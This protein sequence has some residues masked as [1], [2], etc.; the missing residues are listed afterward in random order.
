MELNKTELSSFIFSEN[1]RTSTPVQKVMTDFTRH[2]ETIVTKNTTN[3][4]TRK[5]KLMEASNEPT[6][7]QPHLCNNAVT[8][9]VKDFV[10][11]EP[12][13]IDDLDTTEC[14]KTLIAQTSME[15]TIEDGELIS[16]TE[17][18]RYETI[19]E[20]YGSDCP[21]MLSLISNT[22]LSLNYSSDIPKLYE[23]NDSE[24][25]L[26]RI[27]PIEGT[28]RMIIIDGSNVAFA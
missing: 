28:K 21:S 17:F 16:L 24:I 23:E 2:N 10:E 19:S 4:T 6:S 7:K 1:I 5:R 9:E 11:N 18:S 12:L 26:G 27:Y 20:T 13:M 8:E 25:F 22:P 14:E 3:T 15:A